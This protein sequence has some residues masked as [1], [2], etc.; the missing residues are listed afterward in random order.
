MAADYIG[1]DNI[2]DYLSLPHN[3]QRIKISKGKDVLLYLDDNDKDELISKFINWASKIDPANF[4]KYIIELYG[5]RQKD[6][7]EP[8]PKSF[9]KA[10]IQIYATNSSMI[11]N[12]SRSQDTRLSNDN[13]DKYLQSAIYAN[14]LE[15]TIEMLESRLDQVE[16]AE[17]KEST[18]DRMLGYVENNPNI[19]GVVLSHLFGQKNLALGNPGTDQTD[20]NILIDKMLV[21]EPDFKSQ[22]LLLYNLRQNNQAMYNM[23]LNSLKNN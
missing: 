1:V 11:G 12:I 17:P 5:N 22:L 4:Q 18:I 6:F 8:M 21:L 9:A 16:N 14:K 19:L 7:N 20:I 3:F 15:H 2:V 10:D 23:A 13:S